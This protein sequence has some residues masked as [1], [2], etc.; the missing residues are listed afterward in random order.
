[1]SKLGYVSSRRRPLAEESLRAAR[2]GCRLGRDTASASACAGLLLML[3]LYN[4]STEGCQWDSVYKHGS[5]EIPFSVWQE[6]R[7]E[8]W[9]GGPGEE[10]RVVSQYE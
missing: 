4:Y 6:F 2:P 5:P 1:M 9:R 8:L 10:E 3:T 7:G